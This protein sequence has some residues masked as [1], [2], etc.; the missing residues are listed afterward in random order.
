[1]TVTN[2]QRDLDALTLTMTS[3]FN[4]PVERVWQVWENPRLLERW[5]G[6][7][8]Y[9]ATMVEHDLTPGG[10]VHYFMTS[11]EGDEYHGWWRVLAVDAP[12]RLEFEDGFADDTGAPNPEMPVT[13]TRVTLD[14]QPGG[15][16][17]MTIE[18]TYA[19][20]RG[21]GEGAR[22]GCRRGDD[23]GARPDRRPADG[24]RQ[25]GT[26]R[27]WVHS[28]PMID[29]E[30]VARI[31]L[32]LPEVTEGERYGHR[33]WFVAGKAFAWERPFSKADIKRFGDEV[34]P[35]GPIL[36]VSVADL[37]EKEA[38]LAAAGPAFFT[39]SHFDGYAAVLIQL[40]KVTKRPLR[41]A[42]VDAWLAA[43]PTQLAD[44]YV[45]QERTRRR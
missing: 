39:I 28:V 25:L 40:E 10:R 4:A 19:S 32:A 9:P 11:P 12:H 3:E 16:T 34:P 6:P 42:V 31:A 23:A 33:T 24:R 22:D 41:E 14:E 8:T 38:V 7:P 1:M 30:E 45:E 21:P 20:R 26:V 35:V 36:A 29:V 17:R 44:E 27:S 37:G 43:A 5:W 18:G 15:V 2:V 13:I